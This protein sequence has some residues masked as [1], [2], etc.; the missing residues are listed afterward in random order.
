MTDADKPLRNLIA[1]ASR[2]ALAR[3]IKMR[4]DAARDRWVLLAP[5]RVLY[6]D[7]I[8]VAVLQLCDGSRSVEAIAEELAGTYNAAKEHILGDIV[9]LL[10][11]LADKGVVEA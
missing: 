10:Q 9:P 4:H 8:A 5:E 3:H 11:G 6:P 7:A 1:A 2:P